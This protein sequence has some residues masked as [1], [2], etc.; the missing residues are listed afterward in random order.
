MRQEYTQI[1]HS[2]GGEDPLPFFAASGMPGFGVPEA[3]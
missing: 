1:M 3:A 2:S